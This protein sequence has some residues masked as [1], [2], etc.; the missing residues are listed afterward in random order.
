MYPLNLQNAG[1]YAVA[2]DVEEH[3]ALTEAGYTPAYIAPA[4]RSYTKRITEADVGQ[5]VE[6]NEDAKAE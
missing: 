6:V 1:G 4:K 5:D 2:N 3:I